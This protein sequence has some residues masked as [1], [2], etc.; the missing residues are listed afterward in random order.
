MAKNT[1]HTQAALGR[2]G[3]NITMDEQLFWE[4]RALAAKLR[5]PNI[6]TLMERLLAKELKDPTLTRKHKV[7]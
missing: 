4:G 6:S 2:K 7:S 1:P 5:L 3:V